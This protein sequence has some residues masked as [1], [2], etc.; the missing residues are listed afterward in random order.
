VEVM[1]FVS[2]FPPRCFGVLA[3]MM[4]SCDDITEHSLVAFLKCFLAGHMM[5]TYEEPK[6]I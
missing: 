6:N 1:L 3:Q 4:T 2:V 5:I